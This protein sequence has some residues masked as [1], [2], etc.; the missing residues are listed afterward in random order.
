MAPSC[1]SFIGCIL[2]LA[3]VSTKLLVV[4][5]GQYTAENIQKM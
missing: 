3:F 1:L 2:L 5:L 4:L